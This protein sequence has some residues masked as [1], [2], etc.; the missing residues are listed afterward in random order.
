MRFEELNKY[1][2]MRSKI[3]CS[4][5]CILL[6]GVSV[7][8]MVADACEAGQCGQQHCT[9]YLQQR[10]MAYEYSPV[11]TC[12]SGAQSH[13]CHVSKNQIPVAQDSF[14]PSTRTEY[15]I[16]FEEL[17]VVAADSS[18]TLFQKNTTVTFSV[19]ATVLSAPLYLQH[20]SLL[21]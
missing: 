20:N 11:Q 21:C 15:R 18:T 7:A 16:S 12:C 3:A 4:V 14:L 6:L 2:E 9:C 1:A 5:L 19:E 8:G 17:L 10:T 13:T